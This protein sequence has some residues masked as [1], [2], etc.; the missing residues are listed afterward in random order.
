MKRTT[1]Y[2]RLRPE[3]GKG[4][5]ANKKRFYNSI[6][7]IEELLKNNVRY[8][9]LTIEQVS[10]LCTFADMEMGLMRPFDI[11]WGDALF[12][13]EGELENKQAEE[14]QLSSK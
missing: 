3:V 11:K 7:R 10:D 13:E 4:L 2:D 1:L 14:E 8:R 5:T 6:T 9:A 12:F